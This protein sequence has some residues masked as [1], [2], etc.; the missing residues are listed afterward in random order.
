MADRRPKELHDV[1]KAIRNS[2]SSDLNR[3]KEM[4]V[5]LEIVRDQLRRQT[6]EC[7]R[8]YVSNSVVD[9]CLSSL[10]HETMYYPSRIR[11]VLDNGELTAEGIVS[12]RELALYYRML[13]MALINRFDGRNSDD[14]ELYVCHNQA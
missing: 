1:V 11:Q 12:L 13:Y 5:Q 3:E 8:L 9:N 4:Q 2:V 10:K 6:M 14:D 7:D